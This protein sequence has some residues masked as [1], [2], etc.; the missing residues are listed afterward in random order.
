MKI[1]LILIFLM[2]LA[3]YAKKCVN[4]IAKSELIKSK[5]DVPNAGK[6]TCKDL[7]NEPCFCF[8]G[9]DLRKI[10]AGLVN[11]PNSPIL[12]AADDSP[13]KLDC[14]DFSDCQQKAMDPDLDPETFESVCQSDESQPKW[15]EI[16]NWPG[17][18]GVTGPWFIWCEKNSGSFNQMDSLVPDAAGIIQADID[19]AQ[20]ASDKITRDTAKGPRITLLD[21]CIQNTKN[22]TLTPEQTKNCL[23]ALVREIRGESVPVGD[24]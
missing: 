24:L 12:R 19:D 14:D 13:V 18:T 15:D 8:D 6:L 2:P 3:S 11:N 23:Q 9:I 4:Q 20:K 17:V 5:A 1:I 22:P 21:Q 7:P 16:S 10:K